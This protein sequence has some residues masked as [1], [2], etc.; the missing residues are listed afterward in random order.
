MNLK[1]RILQVEK[2]EESHVVERSLVSFVRSLR[3]E[4]SEQEG[5]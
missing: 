4:Y 5:T 3:L 1:K 2:P